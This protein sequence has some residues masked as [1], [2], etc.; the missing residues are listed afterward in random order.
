MPFIYTH[1]VSLS[2]F[3]YLAASAFLGGVSFTADASYV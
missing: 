3:I 2:C 1:L